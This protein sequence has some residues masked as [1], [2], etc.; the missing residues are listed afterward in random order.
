MSSQILLNTENT[1]GGNTRTPPSSMRRCCFTL[2]NYNN[3]STSSM[4]GLLNSKKYLFIIGKEVGESGTP[5]LQGYIEFGKPV[6]FRTIQR[7]IPGAHIEK[8][9]GD[10]T[11]NIKYCSKDGDFESTFPVP[12]EERCLMRYDNVTWKPWQKDVIDLYLADPDERTVHWI[13]DST[14]NNGKSFLTKYLTLKYQILVASGK[15]ADVFHQVAK[16]LEDKDNPKEFKMV[17]LDI[18]R[19]QADY[20][21]YGL[22]EELKNGLIMSGKYEGGTFAFLPV[23]V[24][25]MA[26]I[27]PDEEKFSKDRWNI[28]YL[29]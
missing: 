13:V 3:T 22:L 20:I 29:N 25:V 6:N 2:N 16:R 24:L 7:L 8:A 9:K 17:I 15:K 12:L 26:N 28:T 5:H 19:H 11:S 1:G 14:G 27:A 21:N 10:R 4:I 18:P 23:H